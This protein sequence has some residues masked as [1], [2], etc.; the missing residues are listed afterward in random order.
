MHRNRKVSL[1]L[2]FL[3]FF[4]PCLHLIA[5]EQDTVNKEAPKE[6]FPWPD[7]TF[8]K[9]SLI[10][11]GIILYGISVTEN[12]GLYSSMDA[13]RDIQDHHAG[14][15]S[16]A[17]KY[18][19]FSPYAAMFALKFSGV[20]SENDLLN[21]GFITILNLGITAVLVEGSKSLT[22][23]W[24]PDSS[25][26]RSMPSGHTALAFAGAHMFF[27]EFK[28]TSIGLGLA[29]YSLAAATAVLRMYNNEHWMSDVIVG[30]GIG[31]L[32]CETA[33]HV[34]PW[35]RQQL[36]PQKK[37]QAQIQ[38]AYLYGKSGISVL[39]RF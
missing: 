4:F 15:H 32:S 27:K 30:A 35:L 24:R 13:Y 31:I 25:N 37:I 34:H 7:K 26:R 1:V 33:Y 2:V 14:F 39:F 12:R 29:A 5:Q 38:P 28:N 22:S 20:Q 8:L 9:R 21:S 3:I 18:L 36:F 11:A 16:E 19:R 10:P 6:K 17:D 23:Y